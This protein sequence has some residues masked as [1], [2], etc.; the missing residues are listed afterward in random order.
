MATAC[1]G[2][3][4]AA[5]PAYAAGSV[6][7]R[8]VVVNGTKGEGVPRGLAVTVSE[9]TG[10]GTEVA[11][12]RTR[13]DSEGRWRLEGF[14]PSVG[15]LFKISATYKGVSYSA[16]ADPSSGTERVGLM[17]FETTRD[18]SVISIISDTVIAT[19]QDDRTLEVAH[20]L[21]VENGSDHT[22][23]G[24]EVEGAPAVLRLPVPK[25]AFNL[26]AVEGVTHGRITDAPDGIA[27][28]DPVQPGQTRVSYTYGV[29]ADGERWSLGHS[30]Y[31]PTERAD[32]LVQPEL[33]VTAPGRNLGELTFRGTT[34][35]QFEFG[36]LLAGQV[37]VAAV[38][39]PSGSLNEGLVALVV[40]LVIAMAVTVV[41]RLRGRRKRRLLPGVDGERE[42]LIGEIAA[43]DTAFAAGAMA[44]P[45]YKS[46]RQEMKSGLAPGRMDR[47]ADPTLRRSP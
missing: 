16:V 43:L 1:W 36:P 4:A 22:Y 18:P 14:D 21:R 26:Q 33:F 12:K 15:D 27:A 40:V 35:R 41:M 28:G 34:Y 46:R 20:L 5:M 10:E 13:V 32:L 31:Y 2:V 17:I 37:I 9:Q 24:D 38:G 25:E 6:S 8:G 44:E 11:N 39:Q 47:M 7:F 30:V 3:V 29:R 45:E 23:I 42:R 19:Q